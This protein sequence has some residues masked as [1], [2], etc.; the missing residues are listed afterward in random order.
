MMINLFCGYI[1][2]RLLEWLL[3]KLFYFFI[4]G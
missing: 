2:F 3:V 1:V 4:N